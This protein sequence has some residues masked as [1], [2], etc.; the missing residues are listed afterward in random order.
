MSYREDIKLDQKKN[1][2]I[3]GLVYDKVT[4]NERERHT[5]LGTQVVPVPNIEL[6]IK[7]E[8]R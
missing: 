3:I 8:A 7:T 6:S 1:S 4:I 2:T 5:C